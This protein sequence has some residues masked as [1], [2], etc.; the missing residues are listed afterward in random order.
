MQAAVDNECDVGDGDRGLGDVGGEDHLG[1]C[2]LEARGSRLGAQGSG[3]GGLGSG[4][5]AM[6]VWVAR[7][8]TLDG[9]DCMC[10]GWLIFCS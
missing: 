3:S 10:F 9:S 2:G 7:N 1:E 4:S 5:G 6:C 8:R